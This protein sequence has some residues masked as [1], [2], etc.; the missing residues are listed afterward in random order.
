MRHKAYVESFVA[1]RRTERQ[2]ARAE[3][4]W[5]RWLRRVALAS[6]LG[7]TDL[8]AQARRRA[9]RS[10]E[11]VVALHSLLNEQRACLRD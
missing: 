4:D 2:L 6:R 1:L 9:L 5:Q 10:A 3:N 11:V 8:A 7:E